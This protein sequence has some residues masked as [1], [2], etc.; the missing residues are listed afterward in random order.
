MEL[1]RDP[2][3]G[4]WVIQEEDDGLWPVNGKCPFCPGNEPLSPL[5]I[6][7]HVNGNGSWQVRVTPHLRP[8]Y[9]IEG[10]PQR[11]AE[12][13]Y[14]KMRG[15]GAHEVVIENPA[16]Q[17]RL[18]Q[19]K[20]ENVAQVLRAYVSRI[21]DLKKDLRF[22]YV[23]VFRDQ[24]VSAGQDMEHPHSQI[25]ATPFIPRRVVY[26]LRS[27]Q[28]HY[29]V[30]ER[31]ILCDVVAQEIA[32]EVRT[33]EY[34]GQFI[35]FCPFASRTPYETWILPVTHHSTFEEDLT[36]WDRQLQFARFLKSILRRMESVEPSFHFVLHTTP[37]V[38]A[39][40][41]RNGHWET[42][43]EDFHWH[44][45]ILPTS[46]PKSISYSLKEVFYNSLRPE[47]AAEDLRQAVVTG[48]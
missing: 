38:N 5:T 14:D 39:K 10:E 33:V 13:M 11:R 2:I 16:H 3:S 28:H 44:F 46:V 37:N 47:R 7:S 26:E 45:E 6:Y 30:K 35:A 4:N 32:D 18:S 1:R 41:D 21:S 15:L 9:R 40:L 12:G 29:G 43:D 23:T 34:D 48:E 8:L 24:G 36:T 25:T 42:L 22:R 27:Y 17:A 19:L 20:D 31:C